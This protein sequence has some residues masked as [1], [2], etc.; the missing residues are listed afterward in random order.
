MP[1]T[2]YQGLHAALTHARI[3]MLMTLEPFMRHF[4]VADFA[5][6]PLLAFLCISMLLL[7]CKY[8]CSRLL[9]MLATYLSSVRGGILH[10]AERFASDL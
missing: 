6:H 1:F 7:M 2:I 10:V 9:S 5:T 8:I 4:A 3:A